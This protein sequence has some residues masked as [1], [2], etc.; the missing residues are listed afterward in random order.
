[1]T[2]FKVDPRLFKNGCSGGLYLLN[3]AFLSGRLNIPGAC[4]DDVLLPLSNVILISETR[5]LFLAF[6]RTAACTL[7]EISYPILYR[8]YVIVTQ[9][10]LCL[11]RWVSLCNPRPPRPYL[12]ESKGPQS[13][14]MHRVCSSSLFFINVLM[15]VFTLHNTH[16]YYTT[17]VVTWR[18]GYNGN[19]TCIISTSVM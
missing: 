14:L 12:S 15:W 11:L 8:K 6:L 5:T 1:M 10:C 18:V 7:G 4:L 9:I 19:V 17:T 16:K 3:P 13:L 2:T